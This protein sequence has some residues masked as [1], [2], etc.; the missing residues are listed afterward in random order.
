VANGSVLVAAV[1]FR[2]FRRRW[3]A[4]HSDVEAPDGF[5]DTALE[6]PFPFWV[7]RHAFSPV[8]SGRSRLTDTVWFVPPT[9]LPR[10]VGGVLVGG[11]LRVMFWWRHRATRRALARSGSAENNVQKG[12]GAA[13]RPAHCAG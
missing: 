6:S 2:P 4:I 13:G 3:V 5:T 9:W 12:S 11:V 1:G 10:R 8:G 7:H